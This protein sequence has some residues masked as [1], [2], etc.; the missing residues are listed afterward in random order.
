MINMTDST[1][2]RSNKPGL[3]MLLMAIG[4]FETALMR[5]GKCCVELHCG[6]VLGRKCDP[7][8]RSTLQ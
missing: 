5:L 4:H 8:P 3:M 6:N 7:V 2:Q 1:I